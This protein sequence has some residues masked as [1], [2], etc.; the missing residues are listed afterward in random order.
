MAVIHT[1]GRSTNGQPV[2]EAETGTML[3]GIRQ[4]V[5]ADRYTLKDETGAALEHYPEQMWRRVARGIAAVEATEDVRTEW[6]ERFY[7]ALQDFKFVPGGRILAGAGTGHEVTFYNCYVIP[8]PHDSR[9]GILEN[10][11]VMTEIMARGGGVGI[12]LSSLRPR[13]SYIRSVNGTASG[14][15]SWGELYSVA[16]GDVIQQG[17]SRRGALMLMLDDWHP[18]IEEFITVKTD[19]SRINHANLSICASDSFMEAVKADGKW[20]LVFPDTTDPE[21]DEVWNGDMA[22][23]RAM[24]KGVT[25]HRTVQA[26]EIWQ[27]ICEAAWRSAEPGLVFMERYQKRSNTWYFEQIRCVNPCGEQGLP[28]WGVCN[29]GAINLS[30]FVQDGVMD[31]ELLAKTSKVAIRFLDNVID[32]TPYFIE[33]NEQQQREGTRRTGLG[34]MGLADALIKMKVRYGSKESMPIVERIYRTIRDASYS[35]SVDIAK[36]KGAF[37]QFD[38]EKYLQGDFIR[39]LPAV[40]QDQ[41]AAHGIRNGVLLTQAPTG[42][43]SLLSGVSSGIEPVFDFAMKRVDRTGEHILY[44]PLFKEWKDAH[45]GAPVPDYFASSND[46]GPEDHVRVQAVVQEYTDSSISKTV[47]APNSYSVADVEELY[48]LA[49]DLGC[50]GITFFRDGSRTPVLSRVEEK[51]EGAVDTD[52][53]KNVD[54]EQAKSAAVPVEMHPRKR[55]AVVEGVTVKKLTARGELYVTINAVGEG[56]DKRPIE[57]FLTLGKAGTADQAYLEALA[58]SITLGLRSGVPIKEHYKHLRGIGSLDVMGIGPNRVLSVPDAIAQVIAEI[59]EIP[60]G[61]SGANGAG[62]GEQA[63]V[64]QLGLAGAPTEAPRHEARHGELCPDCGAA[65]VVYEEGCE[66][67]LVCGYSRC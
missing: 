16:T 53:E 58:R 24:G 46:L 14:P 36:E 23:W 57:I 44:H 7:R 35:A 15:C 54:K 18:D 62:N 40:L 60:T 42:T 67:C 6:E 17:G 8:S 10:L 61:T 29:L 59:Y 32:A 63:S 48:T 2:P 9:G 37:P 66:K 13:G 41:I 21:Y 34:T 50:K 47:N 22:A 11:S 1:N 55:P 20:D 12:N 31:Y 56:E 49:Y 52:A 19:L 33:D 3:D 38:A 30:A 64:V 65:G 5:F 4:K 43:T 45:D 25:V 28:E 26:R 51:K 39:Q 27:K